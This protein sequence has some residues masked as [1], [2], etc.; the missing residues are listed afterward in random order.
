MAE[1]RTT[2]YSRELEKMLY[3]DNRTGLRHSVTVDD[4]QSDCSEEGLHIL[5]DSSA[6]RYSSEEV[7]SEFLRDLIEDELPSDENKWIKD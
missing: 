5:A 4:L 6:P 7:P 2:L 1:I 3:P